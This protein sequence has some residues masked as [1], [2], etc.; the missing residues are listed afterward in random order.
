MGYEYVKKQGERIIVMR[1][2]KKQWPKLKWRDIL[3][4][5]FRERGWSPEN[6]LDWEE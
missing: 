4:E 2:K 1:K 5:N 6:I 3:A